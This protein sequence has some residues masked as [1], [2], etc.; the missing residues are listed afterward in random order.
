MS[1]A[2]HMHCKTYIIHSNHDVRI[3]V[4][5]H[6]LEPKHKTLTSAGVRINYKTR[7]SLRGTNCFD[8][9]VT[10]HASEP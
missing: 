10:R 8:V 1:C 2:L 4:R 3:K 6:S 7:V 9:P 5:R